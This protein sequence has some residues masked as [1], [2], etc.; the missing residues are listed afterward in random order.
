MRILFTL[1][2]FFGFLSA[3][4]Q[5]IYLKVNEPIFSAKDAINNSGPGLDLSGY[6]EL[7]EASVAFNRLAAGQSGRNQKGSLTIKILEE[8]GLHSLPHLIESKLLGNVHFN[9]EIIF[10]NGGLE[11][12]IY[13]KYKF[14]KFL[15]AGTEKEFS[16]E[17]ELIIDIFFQ[18]FEQT[19]Y[20]FNDN[21]TVKETRSVGWD[22]ERDRLW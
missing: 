15:I 11:P 2:A 17:S 13:Q 1:C 6:I 5:R 12:K 20:T 7:T 21:G 8:K 4:A 9:G 16:Y 18:F 14:S 3:N 19:N 22:F 10:T